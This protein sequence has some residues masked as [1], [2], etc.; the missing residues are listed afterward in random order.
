MCYYDNDPSTGIVLYNWYAVETGKL[1]PKGWHVPTDEEM[2]LSMDVNYKSLNL[3]YNGFRNKDGSFYQLGTNGY[4][5]SA[6]EHAASLAW[7]RYLDDGIELLDRY[8]Y[9]KGCGFSVRLSRD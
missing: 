7:G 5:W 1:A 9:Y 6:T 3:K 2:K 8:F 4:W